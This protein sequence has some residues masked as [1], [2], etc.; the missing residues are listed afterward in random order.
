VFTS[1]KQTNSIFLLVNKVHCAMLIHIR[2]KILELN[3]P[4]APTAVIKLLRLFAVTGPFSNTTCFRRRC[5][6]EDLHCQETGMCDH[7]YRTCCD[8]SCTLKKTACDN[9]VFR[10]GYSVY[11]SNA[12]A[13]EYT[14][15]GMLSIRTIARKSSIGGFTFVQRALNAKI[16]LFIVFHISIWRALELCLGG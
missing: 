12:N 13:S 1:D 14:R 11:A 7:G 2:I 15:Q 8:G 6:E 5:N 16:C 3:Y 9:G 4:W 10:T